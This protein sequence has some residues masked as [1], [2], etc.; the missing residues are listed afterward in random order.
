MNEPASNRAVKRSGLDLFA[1]NAMLAFAWIFVTGI[2]TGLNLI[3]GFVVAFAALY[4]PRHIWG[5]THYF[6]RA[7]QLVRLL[8]VFLYEL[9]V[10]GFGVAWLVFQPHMRFK[11]AIVDIPLDTES[12]LE[13]MLFANLISLTPGTLSLD[14][15]DDRKALY[16]HVMD[17]SDA[18]SER[19]D[20]KQTFERNIREALS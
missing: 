17:C 14:V 7:A 18:E 11:S 9:A 10:S 2:F 3:V 6:R 4:V 8:G 15:S 16:V 19:H 5:D 20:M 1:L 12:E 13:I